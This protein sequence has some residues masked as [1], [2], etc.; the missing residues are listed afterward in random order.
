[1]GY[2]HYWALKKE[3]NDPIR[4]K[5]AVEMFKGLWAAAPKTFSYQVWDDEKNCWK[6][7]RFKKENLLFGGLGK[8]LKNPLP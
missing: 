4:F 1:M 8:L 3:C 5:E 6:L 2:T 7:K